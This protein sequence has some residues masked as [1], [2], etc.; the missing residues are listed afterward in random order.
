MVSLV[1]YTPLWVCSFAVLNR[2][3]TP[4][5]FRIVAYFLPLLWLGH[6]MPFGSAHA[7]RGAQCGG[8]YHD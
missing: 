4:V 5:R 2:F 8:G 3:S 1:G 6:A 7:D